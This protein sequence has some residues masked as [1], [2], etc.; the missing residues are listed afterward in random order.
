MIVK[1][2]IFQVFAIFFII[3][4]FCSQTTKSKK[5]NKEGTSCN[6]ALLNSLRLTGKQ[7]GDAPVS[8]DSC[9]ISANDNCCSSIDEIKILKSWQSFS[10]P[11]IDYHV[12]Q[13]TISFEGIYNLLPHLGSLN[14]STI[15]YH[16]EMV[17]WVKRNPNSMLQLQV[18]LS[19]SQLRFDKRT[20]KNRRNHY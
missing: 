18:L 1:M 13:M 3:D 17:H 11:R 20:Q 15:G 16:S 5:K 2:L 14:E 6:Y 7:P 9:Q 12:K 19:T 4:D 8:M 10:I